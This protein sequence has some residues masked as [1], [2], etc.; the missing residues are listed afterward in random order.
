MDLARQFRD[1]VSRAEAAPNKLGNLEAGSTRLILRMPGG[2]TVQYSWENNSL[3]R[4][5]QIGEKESHRLITAGPAGTT[6]A[7]DRPTNNSKVV[8]L[9]ITE[10]SGKGPA[11]QSE[12][13]AALGGNLR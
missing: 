7:F 4:T 11:K 2:A 13:S 12:L 5:E 3:E 6:I 10:S 8:T 9:R 1:D